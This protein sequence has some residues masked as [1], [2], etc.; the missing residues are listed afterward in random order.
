[1]VNFQTLTI[2]VLP[3]E[4]VWIFIE[5]K[6]CLFLKEQIGAHVFDAQ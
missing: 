5:I 1:M 2:E 4:V 3:K 6:M